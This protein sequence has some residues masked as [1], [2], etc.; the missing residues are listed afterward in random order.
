MAQR[1]SLVSLWS[2]RGS[3]NVWS[4]HRS[5]LFIYV[6][7]FAIGVGNG[8]I[9]PVLPLF[10]KQL[11]A[12]SLL[13]GAVV[14]SAALGM[15]VNSLPTAWVT[16]RMGY[17]FPMYVGLVLISVFAA[18][19]GLS[20]TGAM[21]FV[22]QLGCGAGYIMITLPQQ[23][24]VKREI[25]EKVR[26]TVLGTVGGMA[27]ISKLI[28]PYPG[29]VMADRVSIRT[30]LYAKSVLALVT[31][32]CV[33]LLR[34]RREMRVDVG[35]VSYGDDG[36]NGDDE[37]E[38]ETM[39]KPHERDTP[40][41]L[42]LQS[43]MAPDGKPLSSGGAN[44]SPNMQHSRKWWPI[45]TAAVFAFMIM[46]L[47]G[48]L[49]IIVPLKGDKIGM[50]SERIGMAVTVSGA[51]DALFFPMS[52]Y[53]GDKYG[54]RVPAAV[55]NLVMAVG[56]GV[57]SISVQSKVRQLHDDT[58]VLFIGSAII[59]A[60]N[61]V[62][63]G[64]VMTMGAD[65][66]P[67]DLAR[68]STFIARWRMLAQFGTFVAPLFVGIITQ[69]AS[70]GLSTWLLALFGIFGLLWVIFIMIDTKEKSK[71][72]NDSATYALLSDV[73]VTNGTQSLILDHEEED[74]DD[75]QSDNS[76]SE[77]STPTLDL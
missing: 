28:S 49:E 45:F 30:P 21:L 17:M 29:G 56:F 5:A 52:G 41:S 13:V 43:K 74:D 75:T 63:S 22:M 53:L 16:S 69:Y 18:L 11:G 23:I 50:S 9:A 60:G 8:F 59:G 47:R 76:E 71:S 24:Y 34:N 65:L 32:P 73:K 10:A 62:S 27:R 67:Y 35:D 3:R 68:A 15:I 66:A 70:L 31:I 14:S 36:D 51:F 40:S 64:I 7:F 46:L 38:F 54:R 20:Q 12:N 58:I 4:S 44:P 25:D 19:S 77:P 57:L 39:M 42:G 33:F 61:G 72:T 55:A 37:H 48:G 26:G 6:S 1:K 2:G